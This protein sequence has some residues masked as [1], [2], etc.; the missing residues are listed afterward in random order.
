MAWSGACS[1]AWAQ[2]EATAIVRTDARLNS[3][4]LRK[5]NQ[6]YRSSLKHSSK[7]KVIGKSVETQRVNEPITLTAAL[8]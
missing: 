3:S 1:R 4:K 6:N 5:L 2:G 7:I 8:K